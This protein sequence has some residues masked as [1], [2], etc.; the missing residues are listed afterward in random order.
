MT[1]LTQLQTRIK[2][3][4]RCEL[5]KTSRSPVPLSVPNPLNTPNGY[6][7]AFG[8]LGEAP[9]RIEDLKGAPFV[10]PAGRYLRREL[11]AK[12]LN[13]YSAYF[14]NSVCCWPHGKPEEEHLL[15]CRQNLI[16]QWEAV[17]TTFILV[18][19]NTATRALLPHANAHTRNLPIKIHSKVAFPVYHPS[20]ILQNPEAE[21]SWKQKLSD[22]WLLVSG[23]TSS[24]D[25]RRCIYCRKM[26]MAGGSACQNHM[27]WWRKDQNWKMGKPPQ[28]NLELG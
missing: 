2:G 26:P 19:G 4:E 28:M 8:V 18:C 3:C 10:G 1:T 11:A 25:Y 12:N 27:A 17:P 7:R 9:G 22:F 5:C 23:F 13:P 24:D 6:G 20:Y 14:F 15:A 16:D 21:A